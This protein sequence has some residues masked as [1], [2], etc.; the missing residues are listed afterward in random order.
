[1]LLETSICNMNFPVV[2]QLVNMANARKR[3]KE[4]RKNTP[5]TKRKNVN[6]TPSKVQKM[7]CFQFSYDT[8]TNLKNLIFNLTP[9]NLER[10]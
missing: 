10:I 2:L 5:K 8:S 4:Y 7:K 3:G 6:D 9:L 1:M